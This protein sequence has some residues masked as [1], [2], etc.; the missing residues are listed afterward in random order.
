M[1]KKRNTTQTRQRDLLHTDKTYATVAAAALAL[2]K[3]CRTLGKDIDNV[4][5][6]IAARADFYGNARFAPVVVG[7]EDMTGDSNCA[8]IHIGV[9]IVN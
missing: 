6:V 2:R 9:T 1:N 5:H 3:A 4:R 8:F 7:T